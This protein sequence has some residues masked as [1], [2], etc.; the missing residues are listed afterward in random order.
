MIRNSFDTAV[1]ASAI[2][3]ISWSSP[4]GSPSGPRTTP[5]AGVSR[6]M[7][8]D[9]SIAVFTVARWALAWNRKIGRVSD[10]AS[11][12]VRSSRAPSK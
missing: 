11:R 12:W 3:G 8:L 6:V 5:A 1:P 9:V 2:A 10:T 7:P 4:F